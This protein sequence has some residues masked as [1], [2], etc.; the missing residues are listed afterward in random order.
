[1]SAAR[2]ALVSVLMPVRNAARFL[3]EAIASVLSQTLPDFEF[4]IVDD[5]SIDDSPALAARHAA[6][7]PRIRV[8]CLPPSGIAVALNHG[9]AASRCDYI[10][11]L[12][13]DD[14]AE[15]ER[16]A[17]QFAV[18]EANPEVAVL[19]T[20]GHATDAA[21]AILHR[22]HTPT[23]PADIH[24]QLP[25]ANCMVSPSVMMRRAAVLAVGGYRQ[26]TVPC[27]DYDLWLR[28]AERHALMNLPEPLIRYRFH[29]HQSSHSPLREPMEAAVRHAAAERR[30]GRPDPLTGQAVLKPPAP[31]AERN[32]LQ[33]ALR[34]LAR[35]M[36]RPLRE[37]DALGPRWSSRAEHAAEWGRGRIF[38]I[39][40]SYR[41]PECQW[42]IRDLFARARYPDRVSVGVVWQAD[43]RADAGCFAVQTRPAQVRSLMFPPAA[44]R[45]CSWA[46]QQALRL[47]RGEEYA[48]QIDSHMRFVADWDVKMLS[49][50]ARC[51]SPR[52][53]LT[54]RPLHYDPPDARNE[55]AFAGLAADAF[56]ADGVLQIGGYLGPIRDAPPQPVATA[57]CAG[58][59]SFGPARRL[60][61]TPFDPHIY[62]SGEEINLAVRLWTAGWDLFVP[63]EVLVYHHYV[64]S[65]E[66]RTPWLDDPVSHRLHDVSAARLRH[67]LGTETTRDRRALA[68]LDRYGLGSVRSL[69]D[70]EAFAG[71]SFRARTISEP[72]RR[73]EVCPR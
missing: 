25:S 28:L 8:L 9:L 41:D 29:D 63:N 54:T 51:A 22:F 72:A 38:V 47:W 32:P 34:P 3:D 57:L 5:G 46:R 45:G 15:P 55:D 62:F 70:Y 61:D 60:I 44:T 16:L 71:I 14:T 17:R 21:G 13:A 2:P 73:G 24:R 27:E 36:L 56:D 59:F 58:G 19:G 68:D 48:L 20:D 23:E 52:A 49:Q 37:R 66:R 50:L 30:A 53:V 40:P 31:R 6:R 26:A 10:A 67:L 42:T 65:G 64:K 43:P 4:I 18:L 69:R 33:R 7:D 12:D 39:I 35:K 11:R 1:M